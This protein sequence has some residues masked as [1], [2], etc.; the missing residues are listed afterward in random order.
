MQARPVRFTTA[1]A[2]P[3]QNRNP[4]CSSSTLSP[5]YL[6]IIGELETFHIKTKGTRELTTT[7]LSTIQIKTA[8]LRGLAQLD[9][10]RH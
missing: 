2:N 4:T 7:E 6:A 5:P 10:E 3:G 9:G 1:N 8:K